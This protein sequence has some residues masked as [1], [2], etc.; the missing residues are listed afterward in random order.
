MF[1]IEVIKK[2]KNET[3]NFDSLEM[4][5]KECHGGRVILEWIN[6]AGDF[7]TCLRC[8]ERI[9]IEQKDV[10]GVKSKIVLIAIDGKERRLTKGIRVIQKIQNG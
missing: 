4:F 6:F 9:K 5:H 2:E 10:D 1:T 3:F 8:G 7:F